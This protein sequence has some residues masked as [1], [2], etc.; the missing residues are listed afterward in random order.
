MNAGMLAPELATS[1]WL[2]ASEPQTL[3]MHRGKVIVVEVFQMLCPGCVSHSLPQAQRVC[4]TF[5][6][7]DVVVLGLHSVFE[8]HDAMTLV[9]LKAFLHEYRLTFP[10]G[11]DMPG[12]NHPLPRTMATYGM[13]GT[14]TMLLIGR[15][16][17]LAIHHFGQLQD[18]DLGANI[19][20]LAAQ[21]GFAGMDKADPDPA[22]NKAGEGRCTQD[23]CPVGEG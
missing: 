8:H 6:R 14:P 15:D 22:E 5:S 12:D 18:L 19:A 16:G 20:T 7:D 3:A 9:A 4:Q 11:V 17:R 2:N 1:Q 21:T 13:N 10:V 23:A